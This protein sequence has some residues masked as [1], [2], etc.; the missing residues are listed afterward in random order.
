MTLQ[1]QREL[2][3]IGTDYLSF[4]RMI[5]DDFAIFIQFAA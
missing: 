5:G 4:I 3:E 1:S 2:I